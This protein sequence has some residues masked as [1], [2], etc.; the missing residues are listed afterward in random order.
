MT[1]LQVNHA[2]ASF[3]SQCVSVVCS[4]ENGVST[5]ELGLLGRA[6]TGSLQ[7]VQNLSIV[8]KSQHPRNK[9]KGELTSIICCLHLMRD[10]SQ[11]CIH[12]SNGQRFLF[13]I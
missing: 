11:H 13:C 8:P 7:V 1:V 9:L 12:A 6:F 3:A 4:C 10:G 5:Q 2:T